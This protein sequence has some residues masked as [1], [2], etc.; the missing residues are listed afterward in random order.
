MYSTYLGTAWCA[1][2]P[3]PPPFLPAAVPDWPA[4]AVAAPAK[5][6]SNP[7]QPEKIALDKRALISTMPKESGEA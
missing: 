7:V 1:W 6:E 3:R 2:V 4:C 5:P